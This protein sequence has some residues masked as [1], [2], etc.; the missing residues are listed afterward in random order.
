MTPTEPWTPAPTLP[1]P[2]TAFQPRTASAPNLRPVHEGILM[3]QPQIA[4]ALA[5]ATGLLGVLM[6]GFFTGFANTWPVIVFVLAG[7]FLLG[8]R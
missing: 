6:V 3:T 8:R 4:T 2:A 7:A 1:R 5:L